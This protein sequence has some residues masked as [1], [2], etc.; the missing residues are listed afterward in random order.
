MSWV[1]IVWS[2]MA[3][4]SLTL[5][6]IHLFVW[7][8]QRA[9]YSHLLFACLAVSAAVFGWFELLLMQSA[10]PEAYATAL[11]WAQVPLFAVVVS[12][13]GFVYFYFGGGIG[14]AVLAISTCVA[15][16]VTLVLNFTTGVN[17]NYQAVTGLDRLAVGGGQWIAA[18]V[19]VPNPWVVVPQA[20][21]LLLICL[22]IFASVAAWRR[23][24]PS[25]GVAPW[26]W[27]GASCFAS[28][29]RPGLRP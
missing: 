19:G 12:I 9:G 8:R 17:V 6:A 27:A 20:S 22:V 3:A 18:P 16:L 29:L 1:V 21:N 28:A 7:F 15:R 5:A 14:A 26:S 13:A 10:T 25:Q 4:S 11:R 23:G 24:D 2:M